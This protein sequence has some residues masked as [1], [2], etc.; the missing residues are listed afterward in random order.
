MTKRSR[1]YF[2][3]K[4]LRPGLYFSIPIDIDKLIRDEVAALQK[5]EEYK[6]LKIDENGIVSLNG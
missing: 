2:V 6:N 3:R 1:K 5:I 4:N